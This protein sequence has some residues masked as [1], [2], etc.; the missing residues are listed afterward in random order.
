LVG[1]A[2]PRL[3]QIIAR[4]LSCVRGWRL[5]FSDLRL[6]VEA[7]GFL[8][9]EGPN[10]SGKTSLLRVLA[11]FIPPAEGSVTLR[12]GDREFV[13]GEE[14]ASHVGWIGHQDAAKPQLTPRESLDFFANLYACRTQSAEVLARVGLSRVTD[15][16]CQYLSA[17]QK[18]RLALARLVACARPVWLLDEPFASLDEDGRRLAV[19][20]ISE[21]CA[22]GGIAIA[23]THE[24]IPIRGGRLKLG[25]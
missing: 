10:G 16:P 6:D 17:G 12:I 11:G 24:P 7:G 20:F 19:Q 14:R 5:V 22:A 13:E 15:L 4:N 18:R 25:P 9:I 8:V 21:H 23:A 2:G 1:G 3:N